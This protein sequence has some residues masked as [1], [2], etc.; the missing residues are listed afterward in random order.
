MRW[1]YI[2]GLA[3]G[4]LTLTW[5]FS[6]LLSMEPW[7]W[8]E[9]DQIQRGVRQAFGNAPRDLAQFPKMDAGSW[10]GMLAARPAKEIELATILDEPSYIVRSSPETI[11]TV[12]WPDGGHQPYFISRD[13]DDARVIVSAKTMQPVREPLASAV[14]ASRLIAANPG[15]A[16]ADIATL[17]DYDSYYY[18]RDRQAPLPVVRMKLADAE[19]T[20]VYVDPEVAQVVG[21]VNRANRVERWLY[22]GLHTLDF[23]FLYYNRPLWDAV[24]IAFSLGG[25]ALSAIGLYMGLK[26]LRR[27]V[28]RTAKSLVTTKL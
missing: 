19:A 24:V 8:T 25:A 1:H 5:A 3:F 23:S 18:S 17:T 10:A 27:G 11:Q 26:R 28:Y 9:H 12:G 15:V 2:T 16:V 7:A 4:V 14:L 20:W 6:G 13:P 22:N 21:Q